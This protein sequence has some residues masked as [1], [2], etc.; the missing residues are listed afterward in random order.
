MDVKTALNE[1]PGLINK[2]EL[3]R[4]GGISSIAGLGAGYGLQSLSE[5]PGFM[6]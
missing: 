4:A 2:E 6:L 5:S 1:S 3:S